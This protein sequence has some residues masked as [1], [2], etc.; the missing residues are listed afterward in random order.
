MAYS[1]LKAAGFDTSNWSGD[2]ARM[3]EREIRNNAPGI[4]VH[5]ATRFGWRWPLLLAG[6]RVSQHGVGQP[7]QTIVIK[8]TS[9]RLSLDGLVA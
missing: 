2:V 5:A 8:T 4:A 3:F 7:C 9:T 1:L 6:V